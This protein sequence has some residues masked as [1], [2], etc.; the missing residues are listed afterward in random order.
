MLC[1]GN[2]S[3]MAISQDHVNGLDKKFEYINN[4]KSYKLFSNDFLNEDFIRTVL[5]PNALHLI[6][7]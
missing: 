5:V 4:E 6:T 2:I 7:V 1:I 3:K